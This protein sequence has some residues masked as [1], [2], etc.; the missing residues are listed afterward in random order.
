MSK[1][2]YFWYQYKLYKL[3]NMTYVGRLMLDVY[4]DSLKTKLCKSHFY[5]SKLMVVFFHIENLFKFIT[6]FYFTY[7]SCPNLLILVAFLCLCLFELK[8]S[9]VGEINVTKIYKNRI[10]VPVVMEMA[11]LVL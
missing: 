5:F 10:N 9:I 4:S 7:F 6:P 3:C 11:T 2:T 8:Y 1:E